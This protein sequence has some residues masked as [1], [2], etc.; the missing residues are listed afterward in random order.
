MGIYK[1]NIP[2]ADMLM[3]SMRSMGY[4]FESAIADVIDNSI[5]AGCSYV[6]LFFPT[7]SFQKQAVGIL[8]DGCGLSREELFEA[9]CYG[10]SAAEAARSEN[11][12]GRFGLGLKAASLSQ[13]RILT[14]V[15]MQDGDISAYSWDYNYILKHKKWFV[16]ELT[17]DEISNLPYIENLREAGKTNDSGTLVIWEDFDV[18]E[19][20]SHGQVF[21]TLR[22]LSD[23]VQDHVALIFHRYIS[24]KKLVIWIN[25]AKVKAQ[26][27]FLESNAKTTT[28]KEFAI[29]LRD[30]QGIERLI[31]VRPFVL[32]FGSDLTEKDKKLLGGTDNLRTRQGFY[33]YRNQRLIIY[34]TWFG[35]KRS[36]LTKNARIRVDI[37]NS[38]DDIWGID[39][40]KQNAS[41]PK[42]KEEVERIYDEFKS[43]VEKDFNSDSC[44]NTNLPLYKELKQL[45][46]KHYSFV[47]DVSFER[48]VR[49]ENLFKAIECIKVLVVNGL[50][51]SGKLDYKENPSLRVIAV[52]GMAL[53]RGLTLEGLLTSYFYRNTA[54]FDVL[55]Q[56]GRWFGYRKGYEDIFQIWTSEESAI[57]YDEISMASEDLK[58]ELKEMF[59]QRLTP[60]DFG[61]KVRDNCQ[62]LQITAG[63]KMRQS[64]NLDIQES[65]YGNIYETPYISL[66]AT[67]NTLNL[68]QVTWL[69]EELFKRNLSFDKFKNNTSLIVKDVPKDIV[70]AFVKNIKS[71]KVNPS[72]NTE[73]ILDFIT[74]E[75]T[76]G[77]EHWDIVFQS[78][79]SDKCYEIP[80]IA[81]V[82]CAART[83]HVENNA[84]AASSRRKLLS[85]QEGAYG[86]SEDQLNFVK[87]KCKEQWRKE[88]KNENREI[89]NRA[90]FEHLADR[91][92]LLIIMLIEPVRTEGKDEK[93]KLSE[94]REALGGDKMVAFAIGFPGVK[95]AQNI[96][97]YKANK[98]YYQQFMQDESEDIEDNETIQ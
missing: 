50:K 86:L 1:E 73:Y 18:L 8:D 35:L 65:Y 43:I 91:K 20:S 98:I 81:S 60:K 84:I 47:S 27:P 32:P 68:E 33:I 28:K 77:L 16:N 74:D 59:A 72:F 62:E 36:E 6:S 57:W 80:H 17:I 55:M 40:K 44:K 5:S 9:M 58:E 93:K 49:K 7:D 15:S 12:L 70:A 95:G 92:P 4:S 71:S 51:S 19:K 82:R 25:N 61:I 30:S 83:V 41:I 46:D 10:S 31:K 11:D 97:H 75:N 56:M 3:G 22:E 54:T 42:S 45:W 52:G 66:N 76:V 23:K 87:R 48:V 34:G 78:G 94:Y 14:V 69:A 89:P 63:N 85:T 96:K 39:I 37:P 2:K 88:G 26:D 38:L 79:E 53:S 67:H 90:Y 24:A 21:S 29:A 13:C 64:F